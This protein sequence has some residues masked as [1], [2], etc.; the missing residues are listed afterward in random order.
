MRLILICAAATILGAATVSAAEPAAPPKFTTK[1]TAAKAGDK[2]KIEFS[3]DRET[4]VAVFIENGGGK[5]VRHLVAGVLGK[6]PPAPLKPGLAQSVEW[7]GLADYGKPAGS[8]PFKVRVSLGLAP[9]F[10][11]SMFSEPQNLLGLNA[12]ATGPDG[13][14]YTKG[15]GWDGGMGP[16]TDIRV[17]SR[18]GKYL[19]TIAPFPAGLEFERVSEFGTIKT[20]EKEYIPYVHNL[21]TY[22]YHPVDLHGLRLSQMDVDAEGRLFILA[23]G[24]QVCVLDGQGGVPAG[25]SFAGKGLRGPTAPK[26]GDGGFLALGSDGRRVLLCG[27]PGGPGGKTSLP[28]VLWT[29]AKD[30]GPAQLLCGS[31][32]K[33]GSGDGELKDPQGLCSDGKGNLLVADRGNGR[34]CV[35]AEADGKFLAS[36]PAPA[37]DKVRVDPRTGAVY[38]LT[39]EKDKS[40]LVKFSDWKEHREVCRLALKTG[41]AGMSPF[42]AV[43]AAKEGVAVW[44]G[45]NGYRSYNL[46]RVADL[47]T[48]FADPVEVSPG[49]DNML[50]DVFVDRAREEVHV[51]R[52]DS[53]WRFKDGA[54][55]AERVPI[56]VGLDNIGLQFQVAPDGNIY[57]YSYGNYIIRW[58]RAGK[59]VPFKQTGKNTLPIP[60]TMTYQMRGL[61]IDQP[62][63]EIYI[64]QPPVDRPSSTKPPHVIRVYDL[65]G[66]LKRE[67]VA[68]IGDG[69]CGPRVDPA[70]NIYVGEAA[71]PGS[72]ELPEFFK[73]KVP[74]IKSDGK[75]LA[76]PK[77]A[78]AYSWGYGSIVK[79]SPQGGEICWPAG[80]KLE[81]NYKP[82]GGQVPGAAAIE[83]HQQCSEI[84]IQKAASKGVL[85][86]QPGF[87]PV[88]TSH[89]CNCL[90]SYFDV[91][92][93]GRV[94]Y[95]EGARCRVGMLDTNGNVIGHFGSYGNRDAAGK[96]DY[97][98]LAMPIAVAATDRFVYVGDIN[99]HHLV[100]AKLGY[101][102]E[103]TVGVQ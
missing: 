93:F 20:G 53:Y 3:V 72:H 30:R 92:G 68:K 74:E 37:A 24:S 2:V 9:T 51:Y 25:W 90:A 99:N 102:A 47:G 54:D 98:P 48:K 44:V 28:A 42:L 80:E 35:F 96:G 52:G 69:A 94:F 88:T 49:P 87:Y 32:T 41:G 46:L 21:S 10:D 5:V 62:R 70:G 29:D 50:E 36:F 95:P 89:V 38:V 55:Q 76:V 4:D 85:W 77:E 11:K 63:G 22:S 13:A 33:E 73:G 84:R 40:D 81:A 1:P 19:R 86:A 64:I 43:S 58:D 75:A 6:N 26:L 101:A 59:P 17:Y 97:V 65:E 31:T 71:R 78:H 61:F 100:R 79:F 82:W 45:S 7:D 57:G 8:G 91:D 16:G 56:P 67:V 18:E 66:N 103:E 23:K 60:S 12:L 15:G 34:V 14:L 39:M 27:L 83:F